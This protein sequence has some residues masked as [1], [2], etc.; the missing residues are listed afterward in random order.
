[1]LQPIGLQLQQC[2]DQFIQQQRLAVENEIQQLRNRLEIQLE[3]IQDRARKDRD[4][5]VDTLLE[6]TPKPIDTPVFQPVNEETKEQL[7]EKI[8]LPSNSITKEQSTQDNPLITCSEIEKGW[9]YLAALS[10]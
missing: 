9:L 10:S 4:A 7:T 2:I 1:V 3:S 8:I 6:L 5:I